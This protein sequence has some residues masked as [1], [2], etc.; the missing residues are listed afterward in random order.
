[1][2]GDKIKQGTRVRFTIGPIGVLATPH[3]GRFA[4]PIVQAGDFGTY[5]DTHAMIDGWHIIAVEI[6][7][8]TFY[9]P[10]DRRQ[11]EAA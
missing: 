11:F 9:A 10:V 7:G 2:T 3:D 1:M 4:D 8:E 5:H 6:N